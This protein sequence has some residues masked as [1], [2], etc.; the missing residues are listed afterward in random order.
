MTKNTKNFTKIIINIINNISKNE[1]NK[2]KLTAKYIAKSH[3][4]GGQLFLF[5]TG[6][7]HSLAEEALHRAGG[8]ANAC[9]ILDKKIDFSKGIKVASKL[10]RTKGL[11]T[12][13]LKKY[14]IKKNDTII[15]F[16]NSGK[17]K[18]P[19]EAAN[20]AKKIGLKVIVIL[21]LN[22]CKSF[23]N[24]QSKK[25]HEIADI[26]IDN[27]GPIGDTLVEIK[28]NN[29]KVGTSSTIAGSFILNSIFLELGKILK[30]EEPYPFYLSSNIKGSIK[31]NKKLENKF[32]K[33]NKFLK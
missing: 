28:N 19:I 32:S 22:Y 1:N 29:V 31:H 33:R 26:A 6:H 2:I 16:S 10:E 7:N 24:T 14:S 30:K 15:I 5:G 18:A 11:G 4:S 25:L 20:Y 3:I 23:K 17:N 9:P 13:I 27:Y 8:F 21:S 12:E